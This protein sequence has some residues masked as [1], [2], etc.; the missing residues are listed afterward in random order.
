MLFIGAVTYWL[1]IGLVIDLAM[2]MI[3]TY[4]GD[5]KLAGDW[6]AVALQVATTIASTNWLGIAARTMWHHWW[7]AVAAA[8]VLFLSLRV[9][10]RLDDR[11]SA[12]WHGLRTPMRKLLES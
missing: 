11:Y 9:D 6:K 7:L 4:V 5:L 2:L 8:G 10:H 1:L 12:F 3:G